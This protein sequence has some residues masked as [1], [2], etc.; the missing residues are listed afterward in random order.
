M[1]LVGTDTERIVASVSELL[2]DPVAYA[3]MSKATNPYGH[4]DACQHIVDALR[5]I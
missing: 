1:K 4:G 5:N 2:N 3:A